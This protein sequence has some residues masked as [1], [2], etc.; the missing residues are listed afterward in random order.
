[1]S[2]WDFFG[3]LRTK[4]ENG[5]VSTRN[6]NIF[7]NFPVWMSFWAP[8]GLFR[9]G[10]AQILHRSSDGPPGSVRTSC[11]FPG[12]CCDR[13]PARCGGHSHARCGQDRRSRP[14]CRGDTAAALR[15]AADIRGK[16]ASRSE[17]VRVDLSRD[18]SL[19]TTMSLAAEIQ[20]TRTAP[21]PEEARG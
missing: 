2:I 19:I 3:I 9:G 1:M 8:F 4:H 11:R 5:A 17:I 16:K 15:R 7:L 6:I 21:T 13:R 12:R 20:D 10:L 14:H 18:A